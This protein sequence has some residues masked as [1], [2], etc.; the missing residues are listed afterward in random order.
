MKSRNNRYI[1]ALCVGCLVFGLSGCGDKES[2]SN[3]TQQNQNMPPIPVKTFKVERK[4]IVLDKTYSAIIKPYEQVEVISRVQGI[5]EKQHFVEGTFVKKGDLL[6]TIE[7]DS[8]QA[9]LDVANANY[10]KALNDYDRAKKLYETKSISDKEY[11]SFVSAYENAKANLRLAELDFEYTTV[12]APINGIVGIK[13]FDKGNFIQ[14]NTS[15]VSITATNPINVEF[16]IPKSDVN[17]YLKQFKKASTEVKIVDAN[18]KESSINGTINY[19]APQIDSSTN[20]LQLRAKFENS[21]NDYIV[22]DFVHV[23]I[24]G[25][26]I[27]NSIVVPEQAI[28]QTQNGAIVYVVADGVASPRPVML[29]VLTKDGMVVSGPLQDGDNV[30]INN[31]AKLRPNSKVALVEGN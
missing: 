30:I 17:R 5:L 26:Q 3:A 29:D 21:S 24:K 14:A 18:N 25:L 2:N 16:S 12:K 15:L 6:Y 1:Q 19:I 23:A 10:K 9:K 4:N 20:T 27:E 28:L 31:I 7:Q 11:D 22:G 8:Y 13:K